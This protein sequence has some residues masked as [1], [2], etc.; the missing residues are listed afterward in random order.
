MNEPKVERIDVPKLREDTV[1]RLTK[2]ETNAAT[3]RSDVADIKAMLEPLVAAKGF[4]RVFMWI[5]KALIW[6]V[7]TIAAMTALYS[8]LKGF[9]KG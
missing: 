9:G 8:S 2:I 4:L 6:S 1:A 7:A 5:S 3:T